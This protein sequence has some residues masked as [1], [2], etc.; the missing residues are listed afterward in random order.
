MRKTSDSPFRKKLSYA[1]LTRVLFIKSRFER[2]W[3]AGSSP[4]MTVCASNHD[5]F[6]RH[7]P[8]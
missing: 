1:G 6:L 8:A 3:I 5:G 2:G 7:M 4:A